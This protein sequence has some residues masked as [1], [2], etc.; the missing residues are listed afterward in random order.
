MGTTVGISRGDGIYPGLSFCYPF[1]IGL[2]LLIKLKE[3]KCMM[4]FERNT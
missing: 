1:S 2:L 3:G 4:H